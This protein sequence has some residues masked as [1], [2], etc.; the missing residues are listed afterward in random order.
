[1]AL[2]DHYTKNI[3]SYNGNNDLC[4]TWIC[5]R[6]NKNIAARDKHIDMKTKKGVGT[7]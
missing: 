2:K 7:K 6:E 3:V 4:I 5:A 1:M